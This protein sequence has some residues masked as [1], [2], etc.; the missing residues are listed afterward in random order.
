MLCWPIGLSCRGRNASVKMRNDSIELEAKA[1]AWPLWAPHTSESTGKK[2]CYCANLV[3]DL[4]YQGEIGLL[5]H[6]GGKEVCTC[7]A[8]GPLGH[9]LVL[10]TL[11]SRLMQN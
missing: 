7:N 5:F 6:N 2:G 3:I 4:N 8:G 1:A 11:R 10:S 9:F